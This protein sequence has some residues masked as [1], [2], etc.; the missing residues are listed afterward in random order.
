MLPP[1]ATVY[2][3][4]DGLFEPL[5]EVG[6]VVQAGD[7]A[8]D[9]HQINSPLTKPAELRLNADGIVI[10]RRFPVLSKAGDAL[11]GLAAPI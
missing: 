7:V 8:G 1:E 10:Y 2:A 9:M 11:T 3:L 4:E 5:I 6:Q